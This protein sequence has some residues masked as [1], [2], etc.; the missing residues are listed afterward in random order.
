MKRGRGEV[1]EPLDAE[2]R[3]KVNPVICYPTDSLPPPDLA[4]YHAAR[5]DWQSWAR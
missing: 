4:A 5:E 2:A 1:M 3:R